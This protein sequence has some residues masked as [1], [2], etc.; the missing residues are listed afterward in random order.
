[1][2]S[3]WSASATACVEFA[4]GQPANPPVIELHEFA[5]GFLALLLRHR[6]FAFFAPLPVAGLHGPAD[7]VVKVR[8]RALRPR[9]V[10]PARRLQLQE[11]QVQPHLQHIPAVVPS[12]LADADAL[13]IVGPIAEDAVDILFTCHRFHRRQAA[14]GASSSVVV[15]A[16]I[17]CAGQNRA[18]SARLAA[19]LAGLP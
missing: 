2:C 16:I 1:M 7:Q 5:V 6:E 19:G 15:T 3:V 13:R 17:H 9:A 14:W 11:A 12:F 8:F 4:Q 18:G 10:G